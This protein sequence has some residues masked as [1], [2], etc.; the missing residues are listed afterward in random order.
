MELN[1]LA[2]GL[3]NSLS[4]RLAEDSHQWGQEES[5][6]R[7][8]LAPQVRATIFDDSRGGGMQMMVTDGLR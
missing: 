3:E 6:R 2:P 5:R 8:S 7:G 4:W 1:V